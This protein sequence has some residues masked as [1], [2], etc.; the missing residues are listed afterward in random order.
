[1][2]PR[3]NALKKNRII[4]VAS[5][6]ACVVFLCVALCFLQSE[7]TIIAF[8]LF[9]LGAGAGIF[10]VLEFKSRA[11]IKRIYCE[12]CG[13]KFNYDRDVQWVKTGDEFGSDKAKA[14][15]D[16]SCRCSHCD[17]TQEFTESFVTAQYDK[18]KNVWRTTDLAPRIRKYFS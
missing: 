7:S 4:I 5:F 15:V 16:F 11:Q 10:G 1:M 12:N 6:A 18:E 9:I 8:I 17:H 14:S 2:N 3:E 13:E